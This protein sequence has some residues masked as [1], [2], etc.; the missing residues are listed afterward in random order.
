MPRLSQ[1]LGLLF[2]AACLTAAWLA[3][4]PNPAGAAEVKLKNG[5]VLEGGGTLLSGLINKPGKTPAE[6]VPS[7]PV[8]MVN[9]PPLQRYFV[10]SKQV[11][12]ENRDVELG[13]RE[14]IPI[15]QDPMPSSFGLG[16][17]GDF[18][19]PPPPFDNF[20]RRLVKL[21]TERGETGVIQGITKIGPRSVEITARN[22]R[23]ETGMATSSIS[24]DVL[25]SILHN[26]SVLDQKNPDHR[27]TIARLYL[28]AERYRLAEK[29]LA[30]IGAQF[31]ELAATV[32]DVARQLTQLKAEQAVSELRLRRAAG[33][34]SFVYE[35][36]K[37]FPVENVSAAVLREVR[38]ITTQYDKV[39][40]DAEKAVAL[41][42]DLQGKLGAKSRAGEVAAPRLEIA[43]SLNFDNFD[44]L[45][46]FL[47]LS[48]DPQLKPA[49]KLALALSGWLVGSAHATTDLSQAL[50]LW[51]ARILLLDYLRTPYDGQVERKAI[52]EK[53]RSLED[54]GAERV[55]WMIPLLPPVRDRAGAEP[56][57][58]RRIEVGDP[59]AKPAVAYSVL[60]PSEYH[61]DHA[62]PLIV[63]LH[64]QERP[65]SQELAFWGMGSETAARA[66]ALGGQSQRHGYIVIAPEY[67]DDDKR[68]YDYSADGHKI[69]LDSIV[70][71]CKRFRID[72]DRVFL[73]GHGMGG[74]AAFDI[75]FSHPDLFAGVIPIGGV[76]DKYSRVYWENGKQ[77]PFYVVS[78]E[79]DR[80]T[81]DRNR[82][83]LERMMKYNFD[84]I[85]TEYHGAGGDS[86]Y[87]EIHKLF[88]W[89]NRHRRGKMPRLVEVTTLRTT[90]N[91][92][93]WFEF[94]GIPKTVTDVVW[95]RAPRPMGLAASVNEEGNSLVVKSGAAKTR[96][97]LAPKDQAS[98]SGLVDF[99]KRITVRINGR[100]RWNDFLKPDIEAMLEDFRRRADRQR[101]FWAVLDF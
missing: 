41:M 92:F 90:D 47:K 80:D 50:N 12:S 21:R 97:W 86:F 49:E 11:E 24:D 95:S 94:D 22:F 99:E 36:C 27:L 13:R 32:N 58:I 5:C 78:G 34:H 79:L 14:N 93:H 57:K 46:A 85:Y 29:E 91:H 66:S 69:V 37:R 59:K 51:Q 70:D 1:T 96:L 60:L 77:L 3:P 76:S 68:I 26:P 64:R 25:E 73:T 17:I 20:G 75:G 9:V 19:E 53:L 87:S 54:L 18:V 62:Y 48:A 52:L 39:K 100:P 82:P 40:E 8:L 89:M 63:A 42:A 2:A 55:A 72:S 23:W 84:L 56:G 71:A 81:R 61:P 30:E 31:P 10:P 7:F 35:M 101:L 28:Q 67:V 43:E 88:D 74:D 83:D 15:R 6:N 4:L 98:N 65:A 38:E 44:R 33:Q 45:D 16:S